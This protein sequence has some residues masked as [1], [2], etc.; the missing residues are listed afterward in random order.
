[1]VCSVGKSPDVAISTF[2]ADGTGTIHAKF[3]P[4]ALNEV[5]HQRFR[6]LVEMNQGALVGNLHLGESRRRY[7]TTVPVGSERSD[8]KPNHAKGQRFH[9]PNGIEPIRGKGKL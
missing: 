9:L 3:V 2:G 6:S 1:M 4:S 7:K 8:E 5:N